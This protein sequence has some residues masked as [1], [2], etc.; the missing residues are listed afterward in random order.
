ME[1]RKLKLALIGESVA[2]SFSPIIH[3]F[4]LDKLGF[5]CEYELISVQKDGF[6]DAIT[7]LTG[8]FDGFNVTIPY[9]REIMSYM[10]EI[11]G[12]ASIIGS[13]NT[14]VCNGKKG[15]NTDGL[16]LARALEFAGVELAG[17]RALIVGAGGA[18]RSVAKILKDGGASVWAYRR[19]KEKLEEFCAQLGVNA[20]E[21]FGQGKFDIIVNATGVGSK[22]SVGASPIDET[23]F[24]GAEYAIELAYIPSETEFL[25]QAKKRG[26]KTLNGS[27]MLFYQAYYA[28]CLY[29]NETPSKKQADELY[30][31]LLKEVSL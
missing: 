18:G 8:D 24:A 27:A 6:H 30:K 29:L 10:D 26:A 2:N 16:G 19:D 15:Y 22:V 21:C 17:K 14:V 4:I 23:A 1:R 20:W 12:D 28:D 25:R 11:L 13:V 7:R 31:E 3:K 5:D 9:K